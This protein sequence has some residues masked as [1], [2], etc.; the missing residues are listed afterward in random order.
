MVDASSF[1]VIYAGIGLSFDI[2]RYG[3]SGIGRVRVDVYR[4]AILLDVGD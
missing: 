2:Y 4:S 3:L 1:D